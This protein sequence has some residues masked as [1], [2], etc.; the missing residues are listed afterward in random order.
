MVL[1][2]AL[3][4]VTGEVLGH[5]LP[6]RDVTVQAVPASARNGSHVHDRHCGTR[7]VVAEAGRSSLDRDELDSL[8]ELTLTEGL[9]HG[10]SCCLGRPRTVRCPPTST[11][12]CPRIWAPT[13]A[14]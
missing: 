11:G 9:I 8:Y 10:R 12:T 1:C 2:S 4:G 3:G 6:I 14:R 13:A 7:E 5:L